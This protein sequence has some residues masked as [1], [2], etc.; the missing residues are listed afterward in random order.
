MILI[1]FILIY[2]CYNCSCNDEESDIAVFRL[3]N[4]TSWIVDKHSILSGMY[5]EAKYACDTM[6]YK[7]SNDNNDN[8]NNHGIL[9]DDDGIC[10]LV[11]GNIA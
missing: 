5:N 2:L 10:T 6:I 9:N 3:V 1:I 8:L 4:F 7:S 11:L